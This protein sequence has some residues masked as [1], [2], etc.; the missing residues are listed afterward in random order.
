M[1]KYFKH[2]WRAI[3]FLIPAF[4]AACS[5]IAEMEGDTTGGNLPELIREAKRLTGQVE[6]LD[7]RQNGSPRKTRSGTENDDAPE[8]CWDKYE[9]ADQG[10]QEIALIPLRHKGRTAYTQLTREGRTR[11]NIS[12][13]SSRLIV[14]RDT[15]TGRP[16]A[17]IGTYLHPRDFDMQRLNGVTTDFSGTGFT[18]Y[19]ITSATDGR[20][21]AG[22]HIVN[23][24]EQFHFH[25]NPI[26]PHERGERNEEEEAEEEL[27]LFLDIKNTP[28]DARTVSPD[29]SGKEEEENIKCTFCKKTWD[30]CD[31]ITITP[32]CRICGLKPPA[33][34]CDKCAVC[35]EIKVAGN[36]L[37]CSF[38][39]KHP[40]EC[41]GAGGDNGNDGNTDSGNNGGDSSGGGSGG[42]YGTG[43]GTGTGTGNGSAAGNP[44]KSSPTAITSA[45]SKTVDSMKK[46][47]GTQMAVCNFGVQTAFK[48]VFGNTNLPP[49]MTGRANDMVKAWENNPKYWQAITMA[50]AQ[51]YANQGYFV[52]A[53]YINPIPGRSG[54]VVVIVPGEEK[55][56]DSWGS[57]VPNTMDTGR[58]RRE[59]KQWLSQS[60]RVSQKN[61]VYFYYYKKP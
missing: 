41:G 46:L 54:H 9:M 21:L 49:G 34:K 24:E 51:D 43:G 11:K 36:C 61:D 39:K 1:K 40:C 19:F 10:G 48:A 32:A 12:R 57:N 22:R 45:A 50:E 53:G 13:V 52:V 15:L 17:V 8:I 35:G 30:D 16:I 47:Y 2:T 5:D 27:H 20:M 60:F 31:C 44:A 14:R 59:K 38:C 42:G 28:L 23:G 6:L 58:N 26:P 3:V 56:S 18:G 7:I 55:Y 37:C 29:V 25:R 4:L 33:C